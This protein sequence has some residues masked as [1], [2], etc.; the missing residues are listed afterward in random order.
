[1]YHSRGEFDVQFADL[2]SA[3]ERMCDE[4]SRDQALAAAR[5]ALLLLQARFKRGEKLP[6]KDRRQLTGATE[7]LRRVSRGDDKFHDQ[8]CDI[9]DFI[10]E[11]LTSK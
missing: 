11:E 8:I 10:D 9:E 3:T 2:L 4:R 1:V 5:H 7:V 6:E